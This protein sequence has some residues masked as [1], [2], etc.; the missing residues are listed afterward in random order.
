VRRGGRRVAIVNEALCKGCG[1]CA[2]VCPSGAISIRHF[3]DEMIDTMMEAYLKPT[4]E[5]GSR[6]WPEADVGEAE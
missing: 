2:V 6:S 5:Q 3:T 1:T 4:P